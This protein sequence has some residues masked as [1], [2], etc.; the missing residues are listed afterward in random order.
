MLSNKIIRI[1]KKITIVVQFNFISHHR[2]VIIFKAIILQKFF[3]LV[4]M[5]ALD[6]YLIILKCPSGRKK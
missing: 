5:I 3:N 6:L 2:D 4:L 1:D